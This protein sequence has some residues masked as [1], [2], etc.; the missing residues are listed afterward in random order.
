[1]Q[2]IKSMAKKKVF[3]LLILA[4]VCFA[5]S[6]AS[7][8]AEKQLLF[9]MACRDA[10]APFA[11]AIIYGAQERAKELGVKLI[12]QDSKDDVLK[13]IE[14]IEN[15]IA[16]GI[17]GYIN[18][19]AADTKAIIPGIQ[20]CNE[21]GIPVTAV[22]SCPEG[23]KIL[24]WLM[25]DNVV[26][27]RRAGE[28]FID[29]LKKKHGGKVPK[30]V[31]IEITGALGDVFSHDIGKGFH[32]AVDQY[33]QLTFA[34]G[35]GKW[36][37]SITFERV[38]DLLMRHEDEVVGVFVYTPDVMGSGAVNAIEN[39]G[40]KPSK[41]AMTGVCMGPEGLDLIKKGK[42]SAIVGQPCLSQGRF[43][44]QYLYDHIK[45]KPTPKI[46][47]T[48]V[49]KGAIWSP[50][51]VVKNPHADGAFVMLK[52]PLVPL[53]V[54]PDDPRLWENQIDKIMGK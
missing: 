51:P 49:E 40:Y 22:D 1:M 5:W 37:N 46:G 25:N 47:D 43:A 36:D 31:V 13:Q 18:N 27:G 6:G 42:Y 33:K 34:Q 12:V 16:M 11:R 14:Q 10:S 48:V 28:V 21:A 19:S 41:Y 35:E 4:I 7:F 39:M 26:A 45:G 29:D 15:F 17:D 52:G 53:E 20:K 2:N 50:A 23:G 54:S 3:L 9:G 44:V 24:Y 38:S 32:A 30:G 8:G